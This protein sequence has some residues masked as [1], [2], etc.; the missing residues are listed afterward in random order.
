M[1]RL[2]FDSDLRTQVTGGSSADRVSTPTN[3]KSQGAVP[4]ADFTANSGISP[5]VSLLRKEWTLFVYMAA[6][7]DLETYAPK[8]LAEI[9]KRYPQV[10]HFAHVVV[11]IDGAKAGKY[12]NGGKNKGWSSGTRLLLFEERKNSSGS[13]MRELS[14]DPNSSLGVLIA[15]GKGELA[16]EQGETLRAAVTYVMRNVPARRFFLDIWGHGRGWPGVVQDETSGKNKRMAPATL[17]SALSDLPC[18]LDAVG[19]DACF[20]GN[21]LIASALARAGVPL[22]VGSEEEQEKTG[23]RYDQVL[24]MVS[25][26]RRN[27]VS[28]QDIATSIVD[29]YTGATQASI[30][31]RRLPMLHSHLERMG[32]ALLAAGGMKNK[33]VQLALESVQRYSDDG[34]ILA[35]LGSFCDALKDNFKSSSPVA[36]AAARVK[37]WLKANVYQRKPRDD[38]WDSHGLSVFLPDY[39]DRGMGSAFK[40][41]A[42]HLQEVSPHWVEFVTGGK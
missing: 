37:C 42:E 16:T 14:V 40:R 30:D 17:G 13:I 3:R 6:D 39:G 35:D 28:A 1:L 5:N 9:R 38:V 25:Q 22:M 8:D 33:Q 2:A 15:R 34:A 24:E 31:L 29:T 11:L 18:P 20:M 4:V 21:L 12:P 19:F 41:L 23:W 32:A 27:E 10:A 7:N 36:L 26:R